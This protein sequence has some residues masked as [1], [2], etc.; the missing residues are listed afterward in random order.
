MKNNGY[1][2]EEIKIPL[3]EHKDKT[4]I[5]IIGG[6]MT[7]IMLAYELSR[8]NNNIILVEANKIGSGVSS[9]TTA[10]ITTMHNLMYQDIY[11]IHGKDKTKLYYESQYEAMKHIIEIINKEKIKCDLEEVT[12][13]MYAT[14]LEGIKNIDEEYEILKEIGVPIEEIEKIPLN[15]NIEKGLKYNNQFQFNPIKYLKGIVN[16]IKDKVTILEKYK[17]LNFSKQSDGYKV[18]FTNGKKVTANKVYVTTH[19]PIFN[20]NG[21]YFGKLYQ[22]KNYL[23]AFKTTRDINGIFI[24]TENPVRSLRSYKNIGIMVGNSHTAGNNSDQSNCSDNLMRAVFRFD[25]DAEILNEWTNQDVM[26]IDYLPFIGQYSR[27][28][29][30]MYVATA[31]HTW[32]MT[33]SHLAAMIL[34]S[35][36]HKY[37]ELYNPLRFSHLK[38]LL[39][40]V[41]M[42]GRSLN[43]LLFSRFKEKRK[44][45]E[46]EKNNG[47]IITY[48]GNIYAVYNDSGKY[49]FLK[50]N[51]SH[52]NCFLK[53]NKDEKTWDCKCHG[54]RFNIYGEVITG[55]AAKSLKQVKK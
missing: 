30:N 14:S 45:K 32:G 7:G 37:K 23:I 48:E 42:L 4:D 41:K 10:K 27:F 18:E 6:G 15:I 50:P 31:F 20:P 44:L 49:I 38:S 25:N 19:Y 51:C 12:N 5:L 22:E 28:T 1:W 26:S 34:S 3:Y 13:Y 39:E 33:N 52:L 55:P 9:K 21:F 17:A 29:P 36:Q 2:Y 16:V 53:W 47:A 46:I 8:N 24:N 43:G 35:D 54:S 11:K 40:S